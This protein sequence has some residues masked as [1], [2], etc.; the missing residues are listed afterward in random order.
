[1]PLRY[2]DCA[3]VHKT[4]VDLTRLCHNRVLLDHMQMNCEEIFK[5][6]AN[7]VLIFLGHFIF[8]FVEQ[9]G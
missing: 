3:Y 2:V 1:M 5:E 9:A 8:P 4:N 6:E 7:S